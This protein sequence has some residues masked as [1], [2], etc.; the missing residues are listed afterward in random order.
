MTLPLAAPSDGRFVQLTVISPHALDQIPRPIRACQHMTTNTASVDH[1]RFFKVVGDASVLCDV[2]I[3][4]MDMREEC[5][6]LLIDAPPDDAHLCRIP[7]A[8][9]LPFNRVLL[10]RS[11]NEIMARLT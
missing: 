10:V 11:V 1:M 2:T 5:F 9:G 6:R 8:P 3:G 7:K 4:Q